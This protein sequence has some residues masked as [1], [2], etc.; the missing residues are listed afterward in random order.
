MD[1]NGID[2]SF[3]LL[4]I[5]LI[6]VEIGLTAFALYDLVKRK[7]V[8]GDNKWLWGVVIVLI[9]IIGPIIYLIAGRVEE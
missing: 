7:R 3:I 9:N 2:T 6:L 4:L 8:K 5:P 1:N